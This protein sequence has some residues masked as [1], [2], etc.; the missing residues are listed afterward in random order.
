MPLSIGGGLIMAYLVRLTEKQRVNCW[1]GLTINLLGGDS[2]MKYACQYAIVRFL[3]YA[4]TGE[5]ANVGIV[6]TCPQT[7]YF[8]FKLLKRVSRI[9]AF[10]EELDASIFRNVR[11]TF[12]AELTRLR[13]VIMVA[14]THDAERQQAPNKAL[15][16]H[17]FAE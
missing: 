8:D 10:F 5:F 4:E 2:I 1:R 12:T 16:N 3:P 11:K 15:A 13:S 14:P 9:S 17:L 7:G 6:L